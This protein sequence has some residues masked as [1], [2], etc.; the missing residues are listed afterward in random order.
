[1]QCVPFPCAKSRAFHLQDRRESDVSQAPPHLPSISQ[2]GSSGCNDSPLPPNLQNLRWQTSNL[3]LSSPPPPL[4]S[5][6]RDNLLHDHLNPTQ[7]LSNLTLPPITQDAP[8]PGIISR[9]EE[10]ITANAINNTQ[11]LTSE[12]SND[13]PN[14][15]RVES[16]I[17][18]NEASQVP[19]APIAAIQ[20]PEAI[21]PNDASQ[22]S[23]APS[24][25]SQAIPPASQGRRNAKGKK[26]DALPTWD[27]PR[28]R[29]RQ[30]APL[31]DLGVL[32]VL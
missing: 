11:V 3:S 21:P 23:E 20:V 26:K 25:A 12:P 7:R 17:S 5:Y 9:D 24:D 15:N 19:E 2:L 1:M 14:E 18:S 16:I 10:M 32:C 31:E 13:Q 29:G 30:H 6:E 22:V 8:M 4:S 27:A 28:T